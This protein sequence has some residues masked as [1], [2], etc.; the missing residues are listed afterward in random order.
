M[1][2]QKPER[3]KKGDRVA[4]VSLSSGILGEAPF[5]HKLRIAERRLAEEFGLETVVMPH[6]LKGADFVAAHPALR[7]K[8]LTDAF[9]DERIAAV[10]CAIGGDD[11]IRTLPFVDYEILRRNPKIFMGY[12]DS[13]VNHFM[14]HKAGLVSFYGPCVMC[15]FGEYVRMPAYT[16]NAVKSLLFG[17]SAGYEIAPSPV[18]SDDWIPW[19]ESNQ[20]KEYRYKPDQRGYELLQ[21]SGIVSGP[22]MGGCLDVLPMLLATPLW[23]PAADWAGAILFLETSEEKPNPNLFTYIL[24]N[25]AAQGILRRL[26]GIVIGKPQGEVYYE[27]Y[28]QA[29]LQVVAREEGLSLPVLYNVN[30]GHARP[31]GVIP[32]G[33][34]AQLD[35]GAKT[36]RLLES[37]VL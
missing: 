1:E 30:F 27:E 22:L 12:S 2:F 25:F 19:D 24:R 20:G 37:A 36:L 29:I 8:D 33:V 6:A 32:M 23:I 17:D 14:M 9:A 4:V 18:W 31:N 13:T 10:F 28:K 34:T 11:A 21:G 3:L 16:V 26:S 7:A 15:E 35:C 5:L